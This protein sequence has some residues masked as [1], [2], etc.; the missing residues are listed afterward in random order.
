MKKF[1]FSL[2]P[3]LEHR[4][5]IE[6]EKLQIFGERTRALQQAQEELARLNGKFKTFSDALRDGHRELSTDELR[7]H[8]AHLEYLDRRITMQHAAVTQHRKET[9]RARLDALDAGK[10][11]KAIE[12]LKEKRLTEHRTMQAALEQRELDDFNNR[13]PASSW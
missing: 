4:E 11:R 6:D 9:E 13:R 8:Y 3:V 1:R 12:K 7:W 2:E 5:R 10:D